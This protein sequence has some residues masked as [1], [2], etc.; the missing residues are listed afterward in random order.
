MDKWIHRYTVSQTH[1]YTNKPIHLILMKLN[2]GWTASLSLFSAMPPTKKSLAQRKREHAERHAHSQP[3]VHAHVIGSSGK[4]RGGL[5]QTPPPQFGLALKHVA[6]SQSKRMASLAS[7]VA[8][9]SPI[10]TRAGLA[11]QSSTGG[12]GVY[13]GMDSSAASATSE[14]QVSPPI[15]I[16]LAAPPSLELGTDKLDE[17]VGTDKLDEDVD[18]GLNDAVVNLEDEE[19]TSESEDDSS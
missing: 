12:V 17:D 11:T 7:S 13:S 10:L 9:E 19:S 6:R 8:F 5:P 18:F 3:A 15:D 14:S 2:S 1:R 4:T 16:D